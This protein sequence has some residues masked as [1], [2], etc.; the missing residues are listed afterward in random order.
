MRRESVIF[1]LKLQLLTL[2]IDF[3]GG[4]R[5]FYLKFAQ[6]CVWMYEV[7]N[8]TDDSLAMNS[9]YNSQNITLI[10]Y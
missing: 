10:S 5:F 3:M 1:L 2:F 6:V 7:F 4:G 8:Q 9:T